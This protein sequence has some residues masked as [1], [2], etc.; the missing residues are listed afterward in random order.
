LSG[1][2]IE[3][4]AALAKASEGWLIAIDGKTLRGSFDQAHCSLPIHLV[5]A[6][7]H[8]I[9]RLTYRGYTPGGGEG[10]KTLDEDI[11]LFFD[12]AIK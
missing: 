10:E 12:D 1:C 11:Q 5:H 4:T 6:W 2:F 8:T 7:D 9:A 3:L